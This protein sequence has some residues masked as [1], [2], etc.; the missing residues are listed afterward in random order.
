MSDI[1]NI[2]KAIKLYIVD[3]GHAPDFGGSCNGSYRTDSGCYA[4]DKG[5]GF[6]WEALASSLSPYITNLPVDPC[7]L[8]CYRTGG[9]LLGQNEFGDN[10]YNNHGFFTYRY[11]APADLPDEF[12][13]V[14]AT[15]SDYAIFAENLESKA[16]DYG[17]GFG[18]F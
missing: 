5:D 4:N 3:N 12:N 15:D 1:G 2:D 16:S 13:G 18:S 6:G 9:S 14:S 7:G 17:F 8:R 10:Q 11:N